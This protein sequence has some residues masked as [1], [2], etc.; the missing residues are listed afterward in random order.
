MTDIYSV[1][2][3]ATLRKSGHTKPLP[4]TIA[5]DQPGRLRV[6]NVMALLGVSHSTLY[7]GLKSGRYPAP[8]GY[9]G[10]MPYWLTATIRDFLMSPPR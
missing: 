4:P 2:T 5:L 3:L 7:A 1:A 10:P 8:D 6:A 9:D